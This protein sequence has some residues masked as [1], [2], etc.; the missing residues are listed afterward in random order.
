MRP[1]LI[2]SR[3]AASE[4]RR[5]FA[6]PLLPGTLLRPGLIPVVPK[7]E[8]LVFQALHSHDVASAY[9]VAVVGDA[10]GPFNLA[11]EPVIDSARLGQL[12]GARGVPVS[13]RVLRAAA[14]ASFR[15][16]LQPSEPGWLDMAL[17][18]PV[19]DTTRA[20]DLLGWSPK[21]SSLDAL[22][23]LLEGMRHGAGLDTPPLE[24]GGAGPLRLREFLSGVGARLG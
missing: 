6:G 1:G 22:S 13:A 24:P 2:F 17:A 23:E 4:I 19:M 12:L 3:E 11:A 21:R 18:V 20:R 9:R 5:L 7:M 14:A 10:S 8:R 15:L 16:R